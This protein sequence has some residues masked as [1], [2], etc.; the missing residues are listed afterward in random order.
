MAIK[1]NGATAID[2]SRNFFGNGSNLTGVGG[3]QLLGTLNTS[4]ANSYTLTGLNLTSY[5]WLRLDISNMKYSLGFSSNT[6]VYLQ[7]AYALFIMTS[8]NTPMGANIDINLTSGLVVWNASKS[9]T[10][11]SGQVHIP[12]LSNAT[13]AFTFSLSQSRL[14]GGGTIKFYGLK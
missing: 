5:N 10:V 11:P 7:S 2:N 1:V 4:G 6:T 12:T 14:F 8:N 9:T 13:T 3:S